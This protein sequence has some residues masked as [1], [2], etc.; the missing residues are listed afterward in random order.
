[1]K[2][3]ARLQQWYLDQCDEDWEHSYGVTISTLDNPGWTLEIDLTDTALAERPFEPI[4]YGMFE[5]AGTSGI[6]WIFCKV[7]GNK[8]SGAGGPLKLEEIINIFLNWAAA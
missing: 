4:H 8:F 7:D 1:M 5:D 6:E 2:A 3:L